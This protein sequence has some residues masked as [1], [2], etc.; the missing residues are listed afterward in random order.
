MRSAF[1]GELG[2]CKDISEYYEKFIVSTISLPVSISRELRNRTQILNRT[3][4]PL[5]QE[6]S[7]NVSSTAYP[8]K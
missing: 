2:I 5:L 1:P 6:R 4:P 8:G 7:S 3:T